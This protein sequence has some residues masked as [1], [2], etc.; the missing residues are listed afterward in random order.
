M[1]ASTSQAAFAANFP[2]GRCASAEFFRSAWTCSM[3][4]VPAVGLVRG[5]GVHDV[6]GDG[7]EEGVEPP[8]VEQGAL[9]AACFARV[10]VGDAAHH[11]PAGHPVGFFCA[12]NAVKG[13]SATS[14]REIHAAGGLVE[15]RV[16][17]LD[18]GPRVLV[19]R[20]DRRLDLA[21][22]AGR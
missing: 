14:A 10:E 5:D 19:D 17:V 15:D 4:G 18:R 3:I 16:G 13:I 6:G 20:G 1:T 8:D 2:E 7:G 11:Q 21:G 22:P 9:P 12:A